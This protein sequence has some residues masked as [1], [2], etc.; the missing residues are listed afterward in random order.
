M[1]ADESGGGGT[2]GWIVALVI[3]VVRNWREAVRVLTI[4]HSSFPD[5]GA[6]FKALF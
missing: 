2:V 3:V 4:L 6:L 5:S 1:V